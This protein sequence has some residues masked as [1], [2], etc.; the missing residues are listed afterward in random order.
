MSIAPY[1]HHLEKIGDFDE[2]P[3][4]HHFQN[5][6]FDVSLLENFGK[7][8]FFTV[9]SKIFESSPIG[10]RLLFVANS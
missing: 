5:W 2:G 1:K 6:Q 10:A 8:C 9:F 7:R 3:Y 4:K